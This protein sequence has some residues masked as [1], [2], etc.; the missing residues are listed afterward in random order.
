MCH[1]NQLTEWIDQL[2]AVGVEFASDLDPEMAIVVAQLAHNIE[3]AATEYLM[4][5]DFK[6]VFGA[7][8]TKRK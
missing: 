8:K 4:K 7:Q 1:L 2:D 5:I 3:H 6:G